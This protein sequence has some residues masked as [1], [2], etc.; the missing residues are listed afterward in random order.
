LELS[1]SGPRH[2]A[3]SWLA[4]PGPL[5]GFDFVSPN[6]I[7]AATVML[8][9]PAQIFDQLQ[10]LATLS[11]SNT[12]ASVPLFEQSLKLNLKDDL[13]NLLG[14][15]I[16][17]E[18]DDVAPRPVGRAALSVKDAHHL[19]QTLSTLLAALN[20]QTQ[21]VDDAGVTYH[22]L[23]VPSAKA[24]LEIGYAFF[25]QHLIVGSSRDIV[26]DAVRLHKSGQSLGKSRRFVA[27][28][29]PLHS[30]QASAL[31]Y[32]DPIAMAT[33]QLR[34]VSPQ[35]AESLLKLSREATPAVLCLY[36]EEAAIREASTSP[37]LDAAT[38]LIG[39]AVAIPNLLRS[40]I[41]A[42]EATAVGSVRSVN[43]AQA[44]Y[45]ATYPKQ[46]FAPNLSKFGADPRGPGAG[47]PDHA[48]FLDETLA[49]DSCSGDAWCTKSGFQFRLTGIC[50]Q[51]R[52]NEYVVVATPVSTSTGT[53]SFCSTSDGVIHFN[54][55]PPL[56]S[57]LSPTEC[58]S[59]PPIN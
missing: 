32:Q 49:N 28:L 18:L 2:G 27:S 37:A 25:D 17:L 41:A 30:S 24:P 57:P 1:F 56:T 52:C 14:G 39:A 5:S 58:K 46:G 3:A 22:T 13:L 44:A 6:A 10:E 33:L 45:A 12:F 15:E 26:A 35:S 4:K 47:S 59:W 50:N 54:V 7:L 23:R 34:Q 48:G 36:G 20:F 40:K 43:T 53:R 42:N 16:T 55:G 31:F 21:R 8:I 19:Q 38:V 11:H 9:S 51:H 29:P